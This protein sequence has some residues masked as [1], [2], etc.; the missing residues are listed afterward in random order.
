MYVS[1][2]EAA[3]IDGCSSFQSVAIPASNF[4]WLGFWVAHSA[5]ERVS[6]RGSSVI[7]DT[8]SDLLR[9]QD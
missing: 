7:Y 3:L 5:S 9:R 1:M 4:F 8:A 2:S 6:E